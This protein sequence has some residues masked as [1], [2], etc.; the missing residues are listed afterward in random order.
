MKY[1]MIAKDKKSKQFTYDYD[2][3]LIPVNMVKTHKLP[4]ATNNMVYK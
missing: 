2:G 3:K 1:E 4:Q